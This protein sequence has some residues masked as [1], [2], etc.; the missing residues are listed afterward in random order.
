MS[1]S[2]FVINHP[3]TKI[4]PIKVLTGLYN[5][6]YFVT[7][8]SDEQYPVPANYASKSMLIPGDELK[9]IIGSDG[10]L[11]YKLIKPAPRKH[12]KGIL[13]KKDNTFIALGSDNQNYQLNTAA[14]TFFHGKPSDELGLIVHKDKVYG[15]AALESIIK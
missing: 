13:F 7:H 10:S 1:A 14:V 8:D 9:L 5:G 2:S 15:Y 3:V 11:I 6:L 12:I 4:P